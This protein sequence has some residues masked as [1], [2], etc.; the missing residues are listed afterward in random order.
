MK[1]WHLL[2][3]FTTCKLYKLKKQQGNWK[4][5]WSCLIEIWWW[6]NSLKQRRPL[7][8]KISADELNSL[9]LSS[10]Q[11]E[12]TRHGRLDVLQRM[13]VIV[14]PRKVEVLRL[15]FTSSS[16]KL[17]EFVVDF[18]S[19]H[20]NLLCLVFLLAVSFSKNW[21]T[22]ASVFSSPSS[23]CQHRHCYLHVLKWMNQNEWIS[24]FL[25]WLNIG[26]K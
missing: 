25:C 22:I 4:Q 11:W 21:K 1:V 17:P 20:R 3:F 7:K 9:L 16:L 23:L 24:K 18:S 14:N 13:F 6:W 10:Q 15:L 8:K 12:E 26:W 2:E 5:T 19:F